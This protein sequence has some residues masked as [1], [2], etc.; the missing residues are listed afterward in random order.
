MKYILIYFKLEFWFLSLNMYR[1]VIK[2]EKE[3]ENRLIFESRKLTRNF[4]NEY[5]HLNEY[6]YKYLLLLKGKLLRIIFRCV[7]ASL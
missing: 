5:G 6:F 4:L 3:T 1:T 2:G 7:H